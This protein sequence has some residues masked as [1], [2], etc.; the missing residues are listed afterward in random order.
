MI[1]FLQRIGIVV[2]HHMFLRSKDYKL[3]I[4]DTNIN[5]HSFTLSV[6]CDYSLIKKDNQEGQFNHLKH[7]NIICQSGVRKMSYSAVKFIF[8]SHGA[9]EVQ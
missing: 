2:I 9:D 7:L 5:R 1:L 3:C 8:F 6:C 4:H